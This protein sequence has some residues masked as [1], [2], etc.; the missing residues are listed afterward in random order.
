MT[1]KELLTEYRQQMFVAMQAATACVFHLGSP[2][3]KRY[4]DAWTLE[5]DKES[6]LAL[7]VLERMNAPTPNE[8]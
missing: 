5:C 7:V 6:V 1:N 3:E 2:L 4:R 8:G